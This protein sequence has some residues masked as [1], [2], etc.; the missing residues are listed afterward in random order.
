MKK[1]L[2]LGL[3]CI[4][5]L[6]PALSCKKKAAVPKAGEAKPE[7]MLSLIPAEATGIFFVNLHRVMTTEL[8]NKALQ[9]NKNYKKYQ[10]FIDKTGIDPKKDVFYVAGAI[11]GGMEKGKTQGVVIVNLKYNKDSLLSVIKTEKTE[12]AEFTKEDYNGVTIYSLPEEKKEEEQT[13]AEEEKTGEEG[14]FAFLDESNIAAGHIDTVKAVIDVVQKKKQ[15]VFKN[16]ELSSLIAK[17]NKEAMFW[18]CASIPPEAIGK[19]AEQ[20]PMLTNLK[21]INAIS[22]FFDYQNKNFLAEIKVMSGD[23]TKNKQVA[24]LLNGLKAFGSMAAA[25]KPEFGELMNKIEIVSAVDHVRISASIPEDLIN[26]LKEK[27]AQVEE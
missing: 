17:T 12:G 8:V 24:E 2:T 26:K 5:A 4:L 11:S 6:F 7:D 27:E 3:I 21:S 1:S 16:T 14:Y 9:E 23:E 25:K 22:L 19:V 20:N 15:N 13:E 10:E 18:G